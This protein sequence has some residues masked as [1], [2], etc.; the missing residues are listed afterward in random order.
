VKIHVDKI[1][2][3][4]RH[5]LT[6]ED[7]KF[8]LKVVPATWIE[9]LKEVR[10]SNSREYYRPYAFFSRYNGELCVYS[11]RGSKEQAVSA[12]LC[13]LAAPSLGIRLRFRGQAS[14]ADK[15]RI[16]RI[17]RPMVEQ[18]M[19]EITP[20]IKRGWWGHPVPTSYGR[21]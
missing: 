17:I 19:Q 14:E 13:A 4:P 21:T 15:G 9:D 18:I 10:L 7:V 16:N 20:K 1:E 2:A 5:A 11:R 8:I 3:P 12:V 6:L